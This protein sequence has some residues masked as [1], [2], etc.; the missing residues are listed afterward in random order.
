MELRNYKDKEEMSSAVTDYTATLI[1]KITNSGRVFTLAVSG[2]TSPVRFYELLAKESLDWSKVKLLLVDERK[3]DQSHIDSNAGMVH[4]SLVSKIDIPSENV[5]FPD[6]SISNPAACAEEYERRICSH[7]GND[8]PVIDLVAL[9]VGPDGHIASLFPNEDFDPDDKRL[10]IS[11]KAPA[12]FKVAERITMTL[13]VIN[14]GTMRIFVIAG[15]GKQDMIQR[16]M[17][18][19]KSI[20]AGFIKDPCLIYTDSTT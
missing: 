6:T 7:F 20:P 10:I 3:V 8:L 16:T 17:S 5:I 1:N 19:D 2:G 4:K 14:K 9:G 11:T 13:N 18:G 12:Q 15:K